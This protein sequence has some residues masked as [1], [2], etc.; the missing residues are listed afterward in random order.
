MAGGQGE[1]KHRELVLLLAASMLSYPL[2]LVLGS[3]WL[4]PVL[5]TAPA[6][7]VMVRRLRRGERGG[8]VRAVLLWAA[9]LAVTATVAFALWPTPVD[10]RVLNGP[11]Y[12]DEMLGWIRTGEGREGS[13]AGFLPQH[14]LHLALFVA[15]SLVTASALS[16]LMGAVLM[17]FMAFYVASLFRAGMPAGAVALLGWPPWALCRVA[18][19]C[20]LGVVLAEPLLARLRPYARAGRVA[21]YLTGAGAGLLLDG[22]L[23]AA[24]APRWGLWLRGFLP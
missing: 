1:T 18:A 4:L 17:N 24:L 12:R 20:T 8:A 7:V 5:N 11:A 23:K 6:Y 21:P 14:L 16:I 15:L 22:I 13:L 19:F 10:A 3:P 9:A 2:G